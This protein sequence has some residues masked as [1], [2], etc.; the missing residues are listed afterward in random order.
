VIRQTLPQQPESEAAELKEGAVPVETL[1]APAGTTGTQSLRERLTEYIKQ[2]LAQT[3]KI[4]PSE[5]AADEPLERYGID[6]ILIVRLTEAL[7]EAVPNASTTSFFQNRCIRELVEELMGREREAVLQYFQRRETAPVRDE[8]SPPRSL[9]VPE[10]S[11]AQSTQ[12]TQSMQESG[13]AII[14]LSGRYPQSGSLREYWENLKAGKSCIGEIPPDRW[15]LDGFYRP[16]PDEA[17][18]RGGSYAK[19]GGFVDRFAE[20]DA[21]FFGISPR[22]A[23]GVA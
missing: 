18:K 14:G 16:D 20:F 8:S 6:S 2:L 4:A 9:P 3:L 23:S 12:R 1:H 15:S 11:G 19:W 7:R 5:I 10:A 21:R 17:L 13:V 22:E